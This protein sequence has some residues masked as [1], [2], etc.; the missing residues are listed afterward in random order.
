MA[1]QLC[2]TFIYRNSSIL[3]SYSNHSHISDAEWITNSISLIIF[4]LAFIGNTAALIVMF[5]SRGPIRL[6]NS[7]YLANLACADLLRACFMPFT[8]IARMKRNFMFGKMI[9]KILPIVQGLSVAVDVF[10]LV[11]ISIERYLAICRPLLIL[12]LQSI[13]FSDLLNAFILLLIWSL[14]F[15]IALPNLY[16]YNLCSLPKPGRF[17]C[18][19]TSPQ[20]F[21]EQIYMIA[22]DVFYFVI[23]MVVMIALYTLIIRKMY[24]NSTAIQMRSFKNINPSKIPSN[25]SSPQL[26]SFRRRSRNRS[27]HMDFIENNRRD[28][29]ILEKFVRQLLFRSSLRS[30]SNFT[31]EDQVQH[32][33]LDISRRKQQLNETDTI[34]QRASQEIHY[35]NDNIMKNAFQRLSFK[36]TS[37]SLQRYSS[38]HGMHRMDRS[39]RKALQLLIVLIMEFFICWTPLFIYHTIG[40][41]NKNF[42]RSTPNIYLDLIL[43]FSF[44][45]ASCNPLTYY[46]MSKRYRSALY[47]YLRCSDL[48]HN[49]QSFTNKKQQ[50]HSMKNVLHSNQ[51]E[52]S[53]NLKHKGQVDID[54]SP[55][56]RLRS[57]AY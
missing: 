45:S 32:P 10:T 43:L 17:K 52:N 27:E 31:E 20:E 47:A 9:C 48:N 12:K 4:V 30:R 13:R 5:G 19:K 42:Y 57:K 1:T 7:R 11:C 22:L 35:Q 36:K 39:R 2:R 44:A 18:E 23:P 37:I 24:R 49:Q 29:S 46:F 14:G 40:T 41:F 6:T 26:L 56:D 33:T 16:M 25:S 8:I 55:H 28:S 15:L 34:S 21:D 53:P 51:K 54:V 50:L 38:S 3:S